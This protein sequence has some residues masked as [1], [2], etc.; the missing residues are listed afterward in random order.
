M[1][2][3]RVID[4]MR[5][6][7]T[8]DITKK[9]YPLGSRVLWVV[10]NDA[11]WPSSPKIDH[12][13]ATAEQ[14]E[15][16]Y[17]NLTSL[18]FW[19]RQVT[20]PSVTVTTKPSQQSSDELQIHATE[21]DMEGGSVNSGDEESSSESESSDESEPKDKVATPSTG[22]E[23]NSDSDGEGNESASSQSAATVSPLQKH[24]AGA[25]DELESIDRT[26]S[27][28]SQRKDKSLRR[29]E[30]KETNDQVS[31][32]SRIPKMVKAPEP[33]PEKSVMEIGDKSTWFYETSHSKVSSW[34][35]ILA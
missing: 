33:E 31:K 2:A 21:S 34:T 32:S 12:L 10:Q 16:E 8:F 30:L 35:Y 29:A 5:L 13:N 23:E 4:G 28:L 22:S 17:R 19:A 26:S 6:P 15:Q 7:V 27:G 11:S 14:I 24:E 25:E 9:N 1:Y 3:G 18:S 20:E